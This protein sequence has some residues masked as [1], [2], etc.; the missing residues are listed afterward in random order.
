MGHRYYDPHLGRFTQPDPSGQ[1]TN[2]YLHA[3]GDPINRTDPNGLLS[4]DIGGEACLWICGGAGVS[5]N[6]DGNL[7]PYLSAGVGTPGA[8][9]D[10]SLASESADRGWTGEVACGFGP[11]EASVATDGSESVGT[12]GS[13]GKCSGT[14]KYTF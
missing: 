2:P 6:E 14:A 12:G 13:T 11:F 5:V 9:A 3:T 8:S 10:A 4:F 7:R 1:E